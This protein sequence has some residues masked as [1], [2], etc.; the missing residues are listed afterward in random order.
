MARFRLSRQVEGD[1][2]RIGEYTLATW[3]A[4]QASD[5][6]SSLE[7]CLQLLADQPTLGRVCRDIRPGLRR[8]EHAQHCVFYRPVEPGILV[9]RILHVRMLP[10]R[11]EIDSAD[12][13]G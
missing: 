8:M 9:V 12:D 2:L 11:H 4:Q 6:L 13:V 1:V 5:Y 3:G 10:S 7:A